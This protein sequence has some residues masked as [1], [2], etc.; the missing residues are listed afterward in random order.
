MG[1]KHSTSLKSLMLNDNGDIVEISATYQGKPLF[2]KTRPDKNE[3]KVARIIQSDPHPN[4]VNIYH[5]CDEY[6]DMELVDTSPKTFN[7][8]DLERA[9]DY[10]VQ[11]GVVYMDWKPDNYGLDHHGIT[12]VFDFNS[13]GIFDK[14]TG[15]W[16]DPAPEYYAWHKATAEGM[17]TPSSI[18]LFTFEKCE[19]IWDSTRP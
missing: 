19:E 6:I 7:L 11:K 16:I 5:V 10:F 4:I 12:K 8:Q 9:H 18:D 3:Q 15:E 13:A 1:N 14:K 2:R 17:T